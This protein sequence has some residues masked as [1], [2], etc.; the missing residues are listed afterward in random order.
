[1]VGLIGNLSPDD[2]SGWFLLPTVCA[3]L[4]VWTFSL[5][6]FGTFITNVG[7]GKGSW[8]VPREDFQVLQNLGLV[9]VFLVFRSWQRIRFQIAFI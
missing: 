5:V 8:E 2:F 4:L 1:M 6:N 3:L 7:C 9:A